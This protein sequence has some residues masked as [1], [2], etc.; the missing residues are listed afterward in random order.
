MPKVSLASLKRENDSLKDEIAALKQNF[1]ELQ[2][3]IKRQDPQASKNGGEQASSNG[4]EQPTRLITDAETLSTLE[5]YGKSYDELRTE[6]ANNLKQLWSRL[7]LLSSRVEQIGDSVEKLLRYSFQYNIIGLPESEMQESAS[8]TVSLCINLFKAAGNEI[9][10]QDI[11]IAHRIPT[12]TATS[13]PRPIVCKF[14]R[15]I[16]KEQV[17]N[18]RKEASKVSATSIGLPSSHSLENVR[19]FDHLTPLLQQLLADSKKFQKRNGF[20]FCWAKNFVI[21]LRRTDDSRP[22][23]IK[24]HNDLVNFASDDRNY[25]DCL[26]LQPDVT[27]SIQMIDK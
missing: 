25:R 22:I 6:S 5:F 27:F 4:G 10:N 20:K 2:Q 16:A 18:S 17:M 14:T 21:Y 7:N 15:R 19:L 1:E 11:D 23:Q 13:G 24:C 8:K 12:R 9:S 3:S 26:A